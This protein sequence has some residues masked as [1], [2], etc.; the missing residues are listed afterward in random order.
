MTLDEL[1]IQELP[2]MLGRM[3]PTILEIGC[4]DG[5]DTRKFLNLFPYARIFAFEPDPR[6]AARFRAQISDPRAKLFDLAISDKDGAL[7]FHPSGGLPE[8]ALDPTWPKEWDLSGSL[9]RPKEHLRIHP[10][11][12]FG[13]PIIV[14]SARLDTWAEA[15]GIKAVDFIWTDVQGAEGDVIAGARKTLEAT[16]YFYTEYNNEELYE[17]QLSLEDITSQLPEFE[18]VT[19][20]ANDVL[21]RNKRF[22]RNP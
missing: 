2:E 11:C 9:K 8:G 6:A 16:R 19:V 18:V 12:K 15:H 3:D 14:E 21:M 17:G 5:T 7:N 20:F 4:N 22:T 10:W 13:D 1:D